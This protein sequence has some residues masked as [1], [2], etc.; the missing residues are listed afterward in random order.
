[1]SDNRMTVQRERLIYS[2]TAQVGEEEASYRLWEHTS[3]FFVEI[4]LKQESRCCAVGASLSRAVTLFELL[5]SGGVTPC[6]LGDV[7]E[8]FMAAAMF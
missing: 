6:T 3:G 2:A 7:V 1:M 8:D 4:C 5:V